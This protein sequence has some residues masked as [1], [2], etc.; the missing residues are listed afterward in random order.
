MHAVLAADATRGGLVPIRT[1]LVVNWEQEE[2]E[3]AR[4]SLVERRSKRRLDS[5]LGAIPNDPSRKEISERWIRLTR[6]PL[7]PFHSD[8]VSTSYGFFLSGWMMAL[9]LALA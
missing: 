7:P 3:G 8:L 5:S 9:A 2:K 4:A 1:C 6:T